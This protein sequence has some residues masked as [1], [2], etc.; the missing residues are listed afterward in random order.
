MLESKRQADERRNELVQRLKLANAKS[1]PSPWT[2]N[3]PPIEEVYSA[4]IPSIEHDPDHRISDE[5]LKLSAPSLSLTV[6][7]LIDST[8]IS[9]RLSNCFI[10]NREVFRQFTVDEVLLIGILLSQG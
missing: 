10:N 9:V 6:D 2:A 8:D 5:G 3:P 4:V 7:Q 1:L